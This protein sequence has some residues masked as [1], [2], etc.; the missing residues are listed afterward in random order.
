MAVMEDHKV[1]DQVIVFDNFQLIIANIFS[2]GIVPK[3][4]PLGELVEA[5][6]LI[7]CCL[8]DTT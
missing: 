4:D 1:G 3:I 8:N 2:D 7:L 6:A 5:F